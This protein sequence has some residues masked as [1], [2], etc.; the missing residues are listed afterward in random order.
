MDGD[1]AGM[2]QAGR[3]F[4]LDLKSLDQGRRGQPS[5]EDQFQRH[6]PVQADLPRTKHDAHAAAGDFFEQFVVAKPME[7]DAEPGMWLGEDGTQA[8][9]SGTHAGQGGITLSFSCC[10]P[11]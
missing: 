11:V 6:R 4:C 10:I 9:R 5:T 2:P 1:D 3:G 7:F 8:S